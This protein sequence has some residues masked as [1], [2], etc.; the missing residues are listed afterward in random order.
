MKTIS[1]LSLIILFSCSNESEISLKETENI[2]IQKIDQLVVPRHNDIVFAIINRFQLIEINTKTGDLRV[3][4]TL[5]DREV[6]KI[7]SEVKECFQY[8]TFNNML[9]STNQWLGV[10][11]LR[12][13]NGDYNDLKLVTDIGI[14]YYGTY[15][16]D[17]VLIAGRFSGILDLKDSSVLIPFD[18]KNRFPQSFLNGKSTEDMDYELTSEGAGFYNGIYYFKSDFERFD[19]FVISQFF[20]NTSGKL[21]RKSLLKNNFEDLPKGAK[22]LRHKYVFKQIENNIFV[23]NGYSIQNV[24][25]GDHFVISKEIENYIEDFGELEDGYIVLMR[26][27]KSKEY[28]LVKYDI[29]FKIKE[30]L[31]DSLFCEKAIIQNNQLL[32]FV[33][34]NEKINVK[35]IKF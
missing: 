10:K 6:E 19:Y 32:T 5:S 7:A 22:N 35:K 34:E 12:I 16:S 1:L 27:I 30:L 21:F 8:L 9:D 17:S 3:V 24:K 18:D 20:P 25:K 33:M 2:I 11:S 23:S 26:N 29:N 31:I 15:N 28:S 4:F 14:D 13:V